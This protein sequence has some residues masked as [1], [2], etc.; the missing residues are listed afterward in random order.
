MS[1][2]LIFLVFLLSVGGFGQQPSFNMPTTGLVWDVPTK[3]VRPMLGFPGAASLGPPMLSDVVRAFTAPSGKLLLA[4]NSSDEVQ[5]CSADGFCDQLEQAIQPDLV[6]WAADNSA[7]FLYRAGYLQRLACSS[8]RCTADAATVLPEIGDP[9]VGVTTDRHASHAFLTTHNTVY[10]A[11][12]AQFSIVTAFDSEIVGLVL[13]GDRG[14][15]AVRSGQVFE[16]KAGGPQLLFETAELKSFIMAPG[17]HQFCGITT[18][19]VIGCWD[20]TGAP[21]PNDAS[22]STAIRGIRPFGSW[23]WIDYDR[24]S[25]DPVLL[26]R[27]EPSDTSVVFVPAGA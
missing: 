11:D 20:L 17:A 27:N 8:S 25:G 22:V 19:N 7:A 12:S 9:V 14:V 24:A 3:T 1:K 26:L 10:M 15:V 16:I 18:E 21:I 23:I 6:A 4:V 13:I 2:R 5:F